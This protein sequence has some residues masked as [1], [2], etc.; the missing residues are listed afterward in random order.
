MRV[1]LKGI[2]F[3]TKRLARYSA[4]C[5]GEADAGCVTFDGVV[6]SDS[7]PPINKRCQIKS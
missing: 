3:T 7:P 4:G 2:N 6:Q 1:R 5:E